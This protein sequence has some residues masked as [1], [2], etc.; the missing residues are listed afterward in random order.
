MHL[1]TEALK[2]GRW[3]KEKGRSRLSNKG[4]E[5]GG[6]SWSL[7]LERPIIVRISWSGGAHTRNLSGKVEIAGMP[8][9]SETELDM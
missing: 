5:K 3:E 6:R 4:K 2:G 8:R 1:L 9:S 7:T